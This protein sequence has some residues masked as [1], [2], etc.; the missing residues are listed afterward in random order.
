MAEDI[1]RIVFA[2]MR[3][4][5]D[6]RIGG[7]EMLT[8]TR[9]EV[10]HDGSYCKIYISGFEGEEQTKNAVKGLT[11]A[12]GII[13]REI[14]NVLGLKKCPDLKFIADNS[15]ESSVRIFEKLKSIRQDLEEKDAAE[16]TDNAADGENRE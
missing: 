12:T 2:K 4:L 9:C 11:S 3:E 8:V 7:G 10:S 1:R 14:S 6:P 5:K 15:G 16:N 13:K